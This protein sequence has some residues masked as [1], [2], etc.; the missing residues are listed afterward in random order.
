MRNSENTI[1]R[2]IQSLNLQTLPREKF[3]IIVADD[4]STDNSAKLAK[5]AGADLVIKS[6]PIGDGHAR[7]LG[8]N[9]AKGKFLAFIDSDCVAHKNWLE[10]IVTELENLGAIS[11]PISNGIEHSIAWSE[12]LLNFSEFNNFKKREKIRFLPGCNQALTRKSYELAGRFPKVYS[13]FDVEF[14]ELLRKKG[15]SCYFIPEMKIQH[16]GLQDK[17]KF[18]AKMKRRGIG[19]IRTRKKH[20]TLPFSSLST[21]RLFVPMIYLGFLSSRFKYAIEAKK[22]QKFLILLPLTCRAIFSYCKGSWEELSK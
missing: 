21:H 20:S 12:Y 10:T 18:L 7:N 19:F 15:V 6:E 11:G 5:D 3:E 1:T 16:L 13:S 22:L 14:G 2:C 9:K 4:G 8:V 17:N